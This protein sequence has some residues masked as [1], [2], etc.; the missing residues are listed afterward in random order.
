MLHFLYLSPTSAFLNASHSSSSNE[1]KT[2]SYH[3]LALSSLFHKP[4]F[5][6]TVQRTG[7]RRAPEKDNADN[8]PL[9]KKQLV[10]ET[11]ED[12]KILIK[13]SDSVALEVAKVEEWA[14][15]NLGVIR[16]QW[17]WCNRLRETYR[18]QWKSKE[19]VVHYKQAATMLQGQNP[20]N[21]KCLADVFQA[22]GE[23]LDIMGNLEDAIMYYK[24]EYEQ[25][26]PTLDI[27]YALAR[28][29]ALNRL[30]EE[31]ASIVREAI[32]EKALD[33]ETLLLI[34]MLQRAVSKE[35]EDV[36]ALFAGIY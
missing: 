27:L 30:I 24:Q 19:A 6:V 18:G 5:S 23:L 10:E 7:A 12:D 22:L 11:G 1:N 14:R 8:E 21:S 3:N 25:K 34:P 35:W 17:I 29:Y 32:T 20:V 16:S 4:Q 2:A 13:P 28:D 31:A 36:E 9:P 15:K 33:R 26:G